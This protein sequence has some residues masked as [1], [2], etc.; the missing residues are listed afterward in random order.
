MRLTVEGRPLKVHKGILT[1]THEMTRVI[2]SELEMELSRD[3]EGVEGKTIGQASSLKQE[4]LLTHGLGK[5]GILLKILAV[6]ALQ[7][8]LEG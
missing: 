6:G 4:R 8:Y 1:V 3:K 2:E 7:W 5:F